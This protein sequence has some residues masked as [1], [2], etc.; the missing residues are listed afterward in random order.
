MLNILIDHWLDQEIGEAVL[1]VSDRG[2]NF[3]VFCSRYI[4]K[5]R[6]TIS[7]ESL[8]S[9]EIVL[10]DDIPKI[11]KDEA[12]GFFSYIVVAK[13]ISTNPPCVRLTDSISIN[14]DG[15]LPGDIENGQMIRFKTTRLS[16]E[17]WL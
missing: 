17:D 13:V 7:L 3:F 10:E 12:G 16:L 5:D 15:T 14:L 1:V 4:E 6:K 9:K 2:I 11:E 8:L